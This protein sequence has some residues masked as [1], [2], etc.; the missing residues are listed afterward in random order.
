MLESKMQAWKELQYVNC[1]RLNNDNRNSM[2]AWKWREERQPEKKKKTGRRLLV[3]ENVFSSKMNMAT[4][5]PEQI[6]ATRGPALNE[7]P[8]YCWL[9]SDKMDGSVENGMVKKWR[10]ELKMAERSEERHDN[11]SS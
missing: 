4:K 8:R 9:N 11:P 6:T 2:T 5:R 1:Y 7:K 10:L 3:N